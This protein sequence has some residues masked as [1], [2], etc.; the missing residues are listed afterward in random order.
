[1]S[2]TELGGGEAAAAGIAKEDRLPLR[3]GTL[4]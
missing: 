4:K 1:M 3:N 2:K